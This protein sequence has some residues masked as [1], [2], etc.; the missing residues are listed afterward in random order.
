MNEQ[1][2]L[3]LLFKKVVPCLLETDVLFTVMHACMHDKCKMEQQ[4]LLLL[5]SRNF[6][7]RRSQRIKTGII[8][9]SQTYRLLIIGILKVLGVI[10]MLFV[11]N[12]DK[13]HQG[14]SCM[15]PDPLHSAVEEFVTHL[16]CVI[17]VVVVMRIICSCNKQNQK[18]FVCCF[19]SLTFL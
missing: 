14:I 18:N 16:Q 5:R 6:L 15:Y 3:A 13:N 19:F 2:N 11:Q 8:T 1:N 7:Y 9:K 12:K 17:P 4:V 10:C